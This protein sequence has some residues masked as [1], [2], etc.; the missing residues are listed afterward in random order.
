MV[1]K[2]VFSFCIRSLHPNVTEDVIRGV[3]RNV[4]NISSIDFVN[5]NT[6]PVYESAR[7]C[8]KTAFIHVESWVDTFLPYIDDYIHDVRGPYGLKVYYNDIYYFVLRE[9]FNP[10]FK[11]EKSTFDPTAESRISLLENENARLHSELRRLKQS[12][13]KQQ[14]S[15]KMP[16]P[17]A[18]VPLKKR[19]K[20]KNKS[21]VLKAEDSSDFD[22][23]L[24]ITTDDEFSDENITMNVKMTDDV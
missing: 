21:P 7:N 16:N 15:V 1:A 24:H 10:G 8:F 9:S 13:T 2:P 22:D 3:L 19:L 11:R 5:K 20:K 12:H 18:R 4:C 6:R 17:C 23:Y 14:N